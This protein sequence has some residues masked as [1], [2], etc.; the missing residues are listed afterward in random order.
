MKVMDRWGKCT[1][2]S[3]S[4]SKKFVHA[5]I[6]I[7]ISNLRASDLQNAPVPLPQFVDG[8]YPPTQKLTL[9]WTIQVNS[10]T[11]ATKVGNDN[12]LALTLRI[13][14]SNPDTG[15]M[16]LNSR[17]QEFIQ[18]GDHCGEMQSSQSTNSWVRPSRCIIRLGFYDALGNNSYMGVLKDNLRSS[19]I[20]SN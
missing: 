2:S 17:N 8:E 6:K 10:A 7:S 12:M 20:P 19:D 1:Q 13:Y 5:F 14:Q 18:Y 15:F 9:S 3:M 16:N 11:W 4:T